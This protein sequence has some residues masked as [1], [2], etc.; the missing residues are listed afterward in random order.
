MKRFVWLTVFSLPALLSGCYLTN[1]LELDGLKPAQVAIS[2]SIQSLTVVSRCDLDSTFKASLMSSGKAEDFRLDSIL[3]KQ[4]VLG[5]SDALA[6]SPRFDLFNPVV[7]RNLTEASYDPLS[8]IPWETVRIIAG[9]PPRDAV[10]SL[11]TAEVSD[12][13]TK[14][15]EE[16]WVNYHFL[17]YAKTFW[18]LY[19]LSDFQSKEFIFTDTI[20][21]EIDSP[22]DFISSPRVIECI[23]NAMY[24]AGIQ[25]SRRLAPWWTT[26]ERFYFTFGPLDYQGGTELL[27]K[28]LWREAAENWRPYTESPEPAV[29]ARACFNMALTCEMANNITAAFEWLKKSEKLGLNEF[30]LIEYRAK[31]AQRL[32]ETGKLDEQ[33]R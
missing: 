6:E 25:S 2:A 1:M 27:K 10:L 18:R 33:M 21:Y 3:A 15:I 13:V 24:E 16:G 28:G 26:L 4:V 23:K 8:S 7:H 19:R 30:Y 5:C 17:V 22:T 14:S 11:E 32:I 29:A 9:D 20:A 12:T 31:L